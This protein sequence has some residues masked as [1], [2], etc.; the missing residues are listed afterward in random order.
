MKEQ[1]LTALRHLARRRHRLLYNTPIR[2]S[3]E[4]KS[5]IIGCIR[6]PLTALLT[7]TAKPLRRDLS[8]ALIATV[9][10]VPGNAARSFALRL[11][12]ECL[13]CGD[14]RAP[15]A[16][17]DLDHGPEVDGD[18]VVEG[19]F[20]FRIDAYRVQA[21]DGSDAAEDAEA[22]DDDE[23]DFLAV[24]ALD[25]KKGFDWENKD[26]DVGYDVEAGCSYTR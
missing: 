2:Q 6:G 10:L 14:G 17:V 3:L 15:D 12:D 26:P 19:V 22:E 5:L 25:R 9:V 4:F 7:A 13:E 24:G 20:G 21:Y 18:A 11:A 23:A 16:D 1:L 8:P